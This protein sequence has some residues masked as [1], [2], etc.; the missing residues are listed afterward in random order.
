MPIRVRHLLSH[1]SSLRDADAYFIAV[2]DGR[3]SDFFLPGA[4]RFDDG[5]HFA[6]EHAPG[7][8]FTYA[9]I[10]FGVLGSIIERASGQ[11][12]DRY[13]TR[14]VLA[15]LGIAARFDPCAIAPEQLAAA[16]RRR[17]DDGVW[18]PDGPWVA[19]V[20]AGVPRCVY[21]M[22]RMPAGTSVDEALADYELGSN[23]TLFSP[24]GGLRASAE[25]L[26]VVLRLLAG[27]G[28]VDGIRLLSQASVDAMLSDE[29]TLDAGGDN[30]LSAGEAEPGGPTDG[31][32][33]SYGLSVHRIDPA[34]WGLEDAP[35]LLVGHLGEA[36]G[37]LSHA[38]LDPSSG[39][40]I[41]AIITGTADDPA[42]A[43]PGT[44]PL[45][46]VEE[47]ILRWWLQQREP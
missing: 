30:G 34:A 37:V 40:G 23:G 25:D 7:S 12:F 26:V 22:D 5:A 6:P 31:L 2:G 36:Y 1:T 47:E 19:Q 46:R 10:G 8:Y 43:P 27:G 41:V 4:P 16:F 18:R 11:R 38:L 35:A 24:Q 28:V 21:G 20:D 29:W 33:T 45:Y 15:P 13:M 39:D 32:M 44:S 17:G 42:S 3:L 9:N 14:A